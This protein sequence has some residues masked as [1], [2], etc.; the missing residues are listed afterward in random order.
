MRK[1]EKVEKKSYLLFKVKDALR[2][3]SFVLEF[4]KLKE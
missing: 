1:Y 3:I 4:K 2:F